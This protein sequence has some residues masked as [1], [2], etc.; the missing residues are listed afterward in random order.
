MKYRFEQWSNNQFEYEEI[1][2]H[3]NEMSQ[4]GWEL[5]NA[6]SGIGIVVCY[7]RN[8]EALQSKYTVDVVGRHDDDYLA[9]CR[10]AGWE[11]VAQ[12]K[13]HMCLFVSEDGS[14]RP[15]HTDEI[16]KYQRILDVLS[17]GKLIKSWW[18]YYLQMGLMIAILFYG[19]GTMIE[20]DPFLGIIWGSIF[21]SPF[22][23]GLNLA[24]TQIAL[25]KALRGVK[26]PKT[27]WLKKLN[28]IIGLWTLLIIAMLWI[29]T[30]FRLYGG[31]HQ[32]LWYAVLL[33]APFVEATGIWLRDIRRKEQLGSI[34]TKAGFFLF[35]L[36]MFGLPN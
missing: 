29:W 12:M 21:L 14:A 22:C 18:T 30:A 16:T 11:L 36:S 9:L 1:E 23:Q 25:K 17:E 7:Q 5:R 13:N 32:I 27:E 8:P 28:R 6:H 4:Q 20:L 26:V 31:S 2:N 10:D 15:L 34:L 3:L 19:I 33:A 24:Y 35:I